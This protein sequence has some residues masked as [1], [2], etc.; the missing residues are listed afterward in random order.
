MKHVLV[1]ILV[2]SKELSYRND[3]VGSALAL[4]PQSDNLSGI[5]GARVYKM[6]LSTRGYTLKNNA[7]SFEAHFTATLAGSIHNVRDKL[8]EIGIRYFQRLIRERY[9]Q[10]I[11][12]EK[13][14]GEFEQEE[15][16]LAPSPDIRIV[17]LEMTYRGKYHVATELPARTLPADIVA[18]DPTIRKLP[19]RVRRR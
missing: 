7:W 13:I 17:P 12:A 3:L 1:P 5:E 8:R 14:R 19:R 2:Y 6:T 15:P 16:A 18:Y 10:E 4:L 9:G 11:P